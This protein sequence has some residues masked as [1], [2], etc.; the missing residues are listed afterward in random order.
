MIKKVSLTDGITN[1]KPESNNKATIIKVNENSSYAARYTDSFVKH[2]V[3][4]F[5]LLG[6]LTVIW[7]LIDQARFNSLPNALKYNIKTFLLPVMILSSGITAFAE[8]RNK[9]QTEKNTDN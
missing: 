7:S 8:T 9:K 3:K 4:S 1:I 2:S 5:P 6:G